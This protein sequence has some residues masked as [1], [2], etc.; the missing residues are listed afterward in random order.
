MKEFLPWSRATYLIAVEKYSRGRLSILDVQ[1][2][3]RCQYSCMY[4][5]SP[6]RDLPCQTDFNHLQ[7]LLE[8][9]QKESRVFDW[10]F[11]CGLGE[12]V[13]SQNKKDLVYLLEMCKRFGLKCTIFTNG[14]Q[15]DDTILDYVKCD[16]L[17]P[18]IKIDSFSLGL[19][20]KLYGT[21]EVGVSKTL[22]ATEA[23]LKIAHDKRSNTCNV[24]AS[25]VPTTLNKDEMLDIVRVCDKHNVFPLIGQLEYAGRAM[26]SYDDLL[27]SKDELLKLKSDIELEFGDYNVPVCPSV[28]CGLHITHDGS[29]SVDKRSGLSCSWF[30][31]ETPQ[32][33]PLCNVNHISSFS[34]ADKLVF[35]YRNSVLDRLNDLLPSIENHPFGGCGGNVKSLAE[36]YVRLQSGI[37]SARSI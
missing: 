1:L 23:L 14:N 12:P 16:V 2:S 35:H 25:I 8:Q 26:V 13:F 19:A 32:V 18:I 22:G 28:I 6:D 36:E 30:W 34:E 4:C 15:I 21:T 3:G 9:D 20:A 31:L 29:I 27:L 5:D 17:Y 24:A 11:I 33:V 37:R 7:Q 10:L